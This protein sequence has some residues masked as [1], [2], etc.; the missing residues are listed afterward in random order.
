MALATGTSIEAFGGWAL[1]SA[2]TPALVSDDA[3]S[4][5]ASAAAWTNTDDASFASFRFNGNFDATPTVNKPINLYAR[6][7]NFNGASGDEPIPD[8]TYHNHYLGSFIV[9]AVTSEQYLVLAD[10]PL[11]NAATSQEMEFYIEN[12]TGI[13][14]NANWALSINPKGFA[15]VA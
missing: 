12:R 6:L 11:P 2:A 8:S 7:I 4:V 9:D 3:F 10:A 13:E 14:L 1:V 5:I 15:V